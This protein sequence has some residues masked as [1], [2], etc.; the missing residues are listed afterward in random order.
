MRRTRSTPGRRGG[1]L[2]GA[3]LRWR[4][5]V[6]NGVCWSGSMPIQWSNGEAA[7]LFLVLVAIYASARCR[8][9][10]PSEHSGSL[11][12]LGRFDGCT[13][14]KR[15][16]SPAC[17]RRL[18]RLVCTRACPS[19]NRTRVE[20][21]HKANVCATQSEASRCASAAKNC[22]TGWITSKHKLRTTRA[23]IIRTRPGDGK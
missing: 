7:L 19:T 1:A 4:C 21:S 23:S 10:L 22:E 14:P 9:H 20:L 11:A 8:A 6:C 2:A 17:P 13:V 18:Q 5:D 12:C 3:S 15:R 16:G